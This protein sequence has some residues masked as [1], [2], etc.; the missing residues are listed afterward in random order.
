MSCISFTI[1]ITLKRVPIHA[2]VTYAHRR[3]LYGANKYFL[4]NLLHRVASRTVKNLL[5]AFLQAKG[6][7]S[8]LPSLVCIAGEPYHPLYCTVPSGKSLFTILTEGCVL[9]LA[10]AERISAV[11]SFG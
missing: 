2:G 9:A 4:I 6:Y 3:A 8:A 1:W 5:Y 11:A 10:G 7:F